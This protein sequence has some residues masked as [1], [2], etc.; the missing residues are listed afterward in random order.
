MKS[1]RGKN[2]LGP[3]ALLVFVSSLTASLT[4][5]VYQ[6][7]ILRPVRLPDADRIVLLGGISQEPGMR[8]PSGWNQGAFSDLGV[9]DTANMGVGEPS[10]HKAVL[11]CLADAAFFRVL[12][13]SP[14]RGRFFTDEDTAIGAYSVAV[15]SDAFWKSY[16][17]G[18]ENFSDAVLMVAGRRFHVVGVLPAGVDFP[19]HSAIYLP[20]PDQNIHLDSL[21]GIKSADTAWVHFGW[22]IGR[23]RAGV[24][25]A[26]AK[27]MEMAILTHLRETNLDSHHG[28]GGFVSVRR[29]QDVMAMG[30]RDQLT[31]LAVAGSCVALVALGS[32]FLLSATRT[33]QLRKNIAIRIAL[34]APTSALI[35]HELLW[36]ARVGLAASIG[37]LGSTILVL[38]ML[39]SVEGLAIPRMD[40]L[41]LHPIQAVYIVL[42]TGASAV[43]LALPY[44]TACVRTTEVLPILN[45]SGHYTQLTLKP[46]LGRLVSIGQLS[47]ALALTTA[48]IL[49]VLNYRRLATAPRGI[50]PDGVFICHIA[51]A[52]APARQASADQM[53]SPKASSMLST[54]PNH[55]DTLRWSTDAPT[56]EDATA[57]R[58]SLDRETFLVAEQ[59]MNQPGVLGAAVVDPVP[60]EPGAG[61]GLYVIPGNE[62]SGLIA[63]TYRVHGDLARILGMTVVSGRWFDEEDERHASEV[64]IVSQLMAAR[65]PGG[66]AVGERLQF[67]GKLRTVVGVV[68]DIVSNYGD[69]VQPT[70]Y[71]PIAP[72]SGPPNPHYALITKMTSSAMLGTRSDLKSAAGSELQFDD[73]SS[74]ARIMN[75]AGVTDQASASTA[76]WFALLALILAAAS[77][78]GVIATLTMQRRRE[79]AIR[80]CVGAPPGRLACGIIAN[81]VALV[82]IAG[83]GGLLLGQGLGRVLSSRVYGFPVFSWPSYAISLAIISA[84][85]LLSVAA[86][87][88]SILRLSPAEVLKEN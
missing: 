9:F 28:V 57:R 74:M 38:K 22:V 61:S 63:Q 62:L 65:Y 24:T 49:I 6:D 52:E 72:Q 58:V 23:L 21:P 43:F 12:G 80:I 35:L 17:G 54:K 69:E 55:S 47:F 84:A 87:A 13:V 20:R 75:G 71:I 19:S 39:R 41:S 3:I 11:A 1:I 14:Q 59:V 4:L 7:V 50:N 16:L 60:Y 83:I 44:L 31:L 15:I 8:W 32:L 86:P 56:N 29:V 33:A 51:L 79:M 53:E 25:L 64:V 82:A 78:Y 42:A 67:E 27:Q 48:T 88:R 46:L 73:W 10:Q 76:A 18:T 66:R 36:W 40:D 34:G 45:R 77:V 68:S 5:I 85:T 81:A 26:Q 30:I 37:V 2:Q 70:I